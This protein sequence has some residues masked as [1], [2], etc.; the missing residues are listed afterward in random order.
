MSRVRSWAGVAALLV[1]AGC[2]SDSPTPEEGGAG[3]MAHI[4]GIGVDPADGSLYAA[5]HTGLFRIEGQK[6][7]R[8]A[9]RWQDTM[10]FT[11]AGPRHFLASGHPGAGDDRPPHLGLIE[12]NNAGK[13]WSAIALE[14]RADFHALDLVGSTLYGYDSQSGQLMSTKNRRVF[15]PI[16]PVASADIAA[17]P[18]D[19][20]VI[21][22][23]TET[24]LVAVNA[25]SGKRTPMDAPALIFI[26]WPK[27][28][29]L[30]GLDQEG[31]V[32]VSADLG[33]SWKA[34]GKSPGRP[35]ALEVTEKGW[36]AA[37]ELG[38]F[39]SADRGAT[40]TP[41]GPR[42]QASN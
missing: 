15:R 6:A 11:V 1:A 24:G 4:H 36:Y 26:D 2:S 35:A 16:S 39:R 25:D 13:T 22:A 31:T 41:L 27:P 37:S 9:D 38:L 3:A 8:I 32:H 18:R 7:S 42:M 10:A 5:T 12:S 29:L 30:V 28:N 17:D 19:N 23:T 20:G 34:R 40:W 33:R 21:L 14:G